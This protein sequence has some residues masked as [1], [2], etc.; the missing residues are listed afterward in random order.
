M[1]SAAVVTRSMGGRRREP[2]SARE[3]RL[4][5]VGRS[6]YQ[7]VKDLN[8]GKPEESPKRSYTHVSNL[9]T[10]RLRMRAADSVVLSEIDAMIER[11]EK[12][13]KKKR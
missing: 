10:E 6:I 2:E 8:E 4:H 7:L 12:E 5:A 1:A 11:Y 9:V 3:R 13:A